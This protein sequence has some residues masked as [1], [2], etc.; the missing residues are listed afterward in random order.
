MTAV[1]GDIV[2]G[3]TQNSSATRPNQMQ[4][5]SKRNL[6]ASPIWHRW[7]QRRGNTLDEALAEAVMDE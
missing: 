1:A 2:G 5:P 4:L 3:S 6:V 7:H